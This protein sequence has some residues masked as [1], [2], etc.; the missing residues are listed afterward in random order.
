MNFPIIFLPLGLCCAGC[1]HHHLSPTPL[2]RRAVP[3]A[4]SVFTDGT[5]VMLFYIGLVSSYKKIKRQ[6]LYIKR[7]IEARSLKNCCCGEAVSVTYS[8]FV[9][10]ALFIQRAKR[11][12]HIILSSVACLVVPYSYLL[13]TFFAGQSPS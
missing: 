2:Y 3:G 1:L 6:A 8:E 9:C 12:C 10:E 4:V 11:M 5:T 7:N 13:H